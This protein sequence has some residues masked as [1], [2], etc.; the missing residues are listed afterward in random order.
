MNNKI[1]EHRVNI[2]NLQAKAEA[3][4]NVDGDDGAYKK[5]AEELKMEL[6]HYF[7]ETEKALKNDVMSEIREEVQ[8]Q[9]KLLGERKIPKSYLNEEEIQEALAQGGWELLCKRQSRKACGIDGETSWEWLAQMELSA[10]A[11]NLLKRLQGI[12]YILDRGL[13][14]QPAIEEYGEEWLID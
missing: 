13:N 11:L 2:I 9:M 6:L 14:I 10:G 8:K 1:D 3:R 12:Q 7:F 4:L 5:I